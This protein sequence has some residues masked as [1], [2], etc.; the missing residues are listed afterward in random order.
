MNNSEQ[1]PN[2][3]LQP[4][5]HKASVSGCFAVGDVVPYRN[6]RG[7]VKLAE[8]TSFKTIERNG[9]IWFYGIDTVTKAEV[10]YPVDISLQL[11]QNSR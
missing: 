2:D 7:N 5:L 10:F 11:K 8:I 1:Q 6:T 4:D 3:A 9:K